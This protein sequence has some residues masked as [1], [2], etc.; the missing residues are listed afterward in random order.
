MK[1]DEIREKYTEEKI[2]EI[3]FGKIEKLRKDGF[4]L[5]MNT[6]P[7]EKTGGKSFLDFTDDAW[8]EYSEVNELEFVS[9]KE[10]YKELFTWVCSDGVT[11]NSFWKIDPEGFTFEYVDFNNFSKVL[12]T[13]QMMY[14][15][16]FWGIFVKNDRLKVDSMVQYDFDTDTWRITNL[17]FY[18]W[19]GGNRN[20]LPFKHPTLREITGKRHNFAQNLVGAVLDSFEDFV[21]GTRRVEE[22]KSMELDAEIFE[23]KKK[24][25]ELEKKRFMCKKNF[26]VEYKYHLDVLKDKMNFVD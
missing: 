1:Q 5:N 18:D 26:I 3:Y 15:N 10:N 21:E 12:E 8:K 22:S 20:V 23:T 6:P 13:P 19:L 24:L 16:P 17:N 4:C 25:S 7:P 9:L 11:L 2:R 14:L